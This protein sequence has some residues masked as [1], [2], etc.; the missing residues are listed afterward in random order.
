MVTP[1]AASTASWLVNVF[2][3]VAKIIAFIASNS[4][5][6]LASLAD[7]VVDLASQFILWLAERYMKRHDERYPVGRARLEALG[8]LGCACFMSMA[9]VEVV[10]FSAVDL[11]N[12]MRGDKPHLELGPTMYTVL[13]VGTAVKLALFFLCS[14]SVR[15]VPSDIMEALAEDHLNDVWSN[16]AAIVGGALAARFPVI[17][18]LDGASAIG[19]S[20]L[21]IMR[22]MR[23]RSSAAASAPQPDARAQ[24][25]YDQMRKVM[26]HTA[27][28][29][30]I[31][32]VRALA[33]QHSP[34][35]EVDCLR[36]YH[37][38]SRFNVE[39][40]IVLPADM[41]VC[42]SHDI[43]LALQ[44]K[45]EGLEEVERAFVHIDYQ[46]RDGLEHKVERE[47]ML[48]DQVS[49]STGL[50]QRASRATR[51]E[52]GMVSVSSI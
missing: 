36:A 7:S 31:E 5:A 26:G 18:W 25:I 50:Q 30:F 40:E 49:S 19:I 45:I 21:I 32:K 13:S 34:Q 39:L 27:P 35:L 2:L 44:H 38:G 11:Y 28:P 29:E 20:V 41:T 14:A 33:A 12:G 9:A 48:G 16:A 22:W 51:S 42:E 6:V 1:G 10:Q 37:F 8:V 24:V 43:G 3:L 4:K 15:A 23:V 46:T 52:V 17:W 47:L